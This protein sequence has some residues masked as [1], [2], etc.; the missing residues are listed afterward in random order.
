MSPPTSS[1][2]PMRTPPTGGVAP[3][4][5]GGWRGGARRWV[6]A[7]GAGEEARV[8]EPVVAGEERDHPVL[9]E[10]EEADGGEDLGEHLP[11]LDLL[12]EDAV[13]EH[14]RPAHPPREPAARGHREPDG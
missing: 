3:G 8:D 14:A 7:G 10:E 13:D 4:G 2:T 6:G 11:A 1:G 5:R 9:D 12:H